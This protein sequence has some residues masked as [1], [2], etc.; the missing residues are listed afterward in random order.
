[1]GSLIG[2]V[3]Q[4]LF[5]L[6]DNSVISLLRQSPVQ[7][8][9]DKALIPDYYQDLFAHGARF[10]CK[11]LKESSCDVGRNAPTGTISLPVHGHY[12]IVIL[13]GKAIL[14]RRGSS[15]LTRLRIGPMIDSY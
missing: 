4:G 8:I 6:L 10:L 12:I 2:Q 14:M 13:A 9:S 3:V 7:Q 5:V 11:A 1:M 15:W